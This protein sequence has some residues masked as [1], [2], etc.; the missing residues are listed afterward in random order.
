MTVIEVAPKDI[1]VLVDFPIKELVQLKLIM[2]NM[3]FNCDSSNKQHLEANK[4][5]HETF[6][7]AITELLKELTNGA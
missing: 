1:H 6:Y 3:E 4:F 5:L 2:D 7:P